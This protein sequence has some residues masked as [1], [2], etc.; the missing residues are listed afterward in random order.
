M[1]VDFGSVDVHCEGLVYGV[2][3]DGDNAIAISEEVFEDG[4]VG[5][6]KNYMVVGRRKVCIPGGELGPKPGLEPCS[7]R[8][9]ADRRHRC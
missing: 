1:R 8:E 9:L 2:V 7:A 3:C 4:E 5:L 6:R